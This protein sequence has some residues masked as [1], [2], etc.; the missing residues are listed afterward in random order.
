VRRIALKLHAFQIG[1]FDMEVTTR[2]VGQRLVV[3]NPKLLPEL[4]L[5]D[6][7]GCR[8]LFLQDLQ[9]VR[10]PKNERL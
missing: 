5:G 10:F 1:T 7:P 3:W 2:P 4:L 8:Q 9:K 6:L